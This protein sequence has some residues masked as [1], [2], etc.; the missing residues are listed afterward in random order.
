MTLVSG[1]IELLGK[2]V[3][4]SYVVPGM[5]HRR[6]DRAVLVITFCESALLRLGQGYGGVRH[7]QRNRDLLLKNFFVGHAVD[8]FEDD[9][10]E[11]GS[12]V[13]VAELFARDGLELHLM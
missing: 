10:E 11:H 8:V 7:A 9:A 3:A 2:L 6:D 12:R 4:G 5:N 13:G 1:S